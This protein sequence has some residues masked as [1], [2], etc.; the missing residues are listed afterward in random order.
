MGN[1]MMN[2]V[3]KYTLPIDTEEFELNMPAGAQI[4]SVRIQR[5]FPVLWALVDINL[6]KA[7]RKFKVFPTGRPF[8][9]LG[10]EYVSTYE[11][12]YLVYHLFEVIKEYSNGDANRS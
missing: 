11:T 6:E 7:P 9:I 4:L 2:Q 3:W 12:R 10:L 5:D 1:N 8:S